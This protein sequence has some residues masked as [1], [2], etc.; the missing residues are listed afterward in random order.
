[1]DRNSNRV[2]NGADISIT[3]TDAPAGKCAI[4]VPSDATTELATGTYTDRLRITVGGVTS[5]LST[6]TINVTADA[7]K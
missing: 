4:L 3:V 5:T 1:M 7:F 2:I 6:G